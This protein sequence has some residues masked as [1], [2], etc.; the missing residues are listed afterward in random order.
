M[1]LAGLAELAQQLEAV[2]VEDIHHVV[3]RCR[4]RKRSGF[5]GQW[6]CRRGAPALPPERRFLLVLGV[7]YQ[8]VVQAGVGHKEAVIVVQRHAGD[9]AEV[10]LLAVTDQLHV[11]VVLGIE[12]EYRGTDSRKLRRKLLFTA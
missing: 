7:E 6:P 5:P 2:G 10:R 9:D 3:A 8:H 11:V 4:P 1:L 12:N